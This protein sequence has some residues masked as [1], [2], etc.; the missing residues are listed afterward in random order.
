[1][2]LSR[3]VAAQ[4]A[5][6][7]LLGV[8]WSWFAWNHFDAY[9]ATGIVVFLLFFIGESI[10]AILFVI[11]RVPRET[12]TDVRDWLIAGIGA[13]VVLCFTP[14]GAVVWED[15]KYFIVAGFLLQMFSLI[16]LNRSFSI[17][18]AN[19]GIQRSGAYRIIRH[20][21]YASYILSI[22]GYLLF[23]ASPQ[24]IFI[25]GVFLVFTYLRIEAEERLLLRDKNYE[26]YCHVVRF[27]LIPYVY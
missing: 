12:A 19:R 24:N 26:A 11:R 20:P 5:M 6:G 27:R 22:V 14:G 18:A 1:M 13:F 4:R 3:S 2:R 10:Q 16:S 15:G 7:V 8:A 23:N 25:F 17:V 9:R 21:M